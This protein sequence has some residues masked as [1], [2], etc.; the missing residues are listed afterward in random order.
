S[1][2]GIVNRT[3]TPANISVPRRGHAKILDFGLAK[4]SVSKTTAG[5][6]GS[7]LATFGV[8][9]DQL[10]SPGST[11][12]TVAYM[13]PEQ[14]LGKEL[15]P[16]S[17]LFS[18]GVVFYEMATGSL[19]FQGQSSGAVF[20]AILHKTPVPV[21]RCNPNLPH[22]FEQILSKCLEKDRDLRCQTAAELPADLKRLK[23]D[24]GSG[25]SVAASGS[26]TAL[27]PANSPIP[28]PAIISTPSA[29]SASAAT[30]SLHPRVSRKPS[31]AGAAAVL[32]LLAAAGYLK[33]VKPSAPT[34]DLRMVQ[35]RKLTD[36]GHVVVAS[37]VSL[38]QDGKWIAYAK[39]DQSRSLWVK[40]IVTGSEVEVARLKPDLYFRGQSFTPDGN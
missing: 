1:S 9:S 38:S 4:V 13:S 18:F 2:K 27:A 11:L 10:T 34:F 16:R 37:G 33:W 28:P 32:V 24:T 6:A 40:Q 15:D 14:V 7:T 21:A 25:K 39:R 35:I 12:G 26:A 23:R 17:D 31:I 36:H 20:D 22:E 8:D 5:A 30:L 29:P 3:T 19:P